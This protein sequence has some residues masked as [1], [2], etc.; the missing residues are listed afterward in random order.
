MPFFFFVV[1]KAR[2]L[3]PSMVE[4]LSVA[5]GSDVQALKLGS[6]EVMLLHKPGN[7]DRITK[8]N[9]QK[10]KFSEFGLGI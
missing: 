5:N 2:A 3:E 9:G 8:K 10:Q 7:N 4:K 1:L 6:F